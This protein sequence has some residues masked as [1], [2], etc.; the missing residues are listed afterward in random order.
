ME[1]E[2]VQEEF[3]KLY[4]KEGKEYFS[5]GR[6]NLI[7]EHVDYN[8]GYVFPCA[9]S[10]GTFGVAAKRD[11]DILN[12]AST[13]FDFK[14]TCKLN[15]LSYKKEDNWANYLK[16]IFVEMQKLGAKLSG[17]DIL[18][19]GN[20]PNGSGLSSSS[21]IELLMSVILNDMYDL[22]ISKVD[23]ALLS[24]RVENNYMGVNS[25]IMDQFSI[26]LGK[27]NNAILID[28][29]TLDYEYVPLELGDYKLII[30]NTKKRRELAD[31]KYNERRAECD[32]ALE[33]LHQKFNVEFL[34]DIS[35]EDFEKNKDLIKEENVLKRATHVIYE[36]K[37]TLEA[38]KALKASELEKFGALMIES[39]NS[40]RDLYEVTGIELDTLVEESL[41]IK[42]V[43]G[44]RMTGAGFGGC[45]VSIVP[46][47]MIEEFKA[48]VGKAYKEKIGY[49]AE[50][51]VA[52]VGDGA[53][54]L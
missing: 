51:Y 26:S 20:I 18:I 34:R 1:I 11:D 38:V 9:L 36:I 43:L 49:D 13:D 4:G 44:S 33:Y 27:K 39:H 15:D 23:M 3:K 52:D 24:Q 19:S 28:C 25:G 7:G 21:S 53:S 30:G 10:F 46:S 12:F 45:T 48:T 41:K 47:N 6:V 2:K 37:R 54:V 16:G 8:G 22:K 50:F 17:M 42:G 32:K 40:L 35:P 5:P 29:K 31:S 14:V